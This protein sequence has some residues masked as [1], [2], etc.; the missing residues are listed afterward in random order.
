MPKS[1]VKLLPRPDP[2][3]HLS[4]QGYST[5]KKASTR[6]IALK[7]SSKKYGTLPVLKRLNLIRNLTPPDMPAHKVMASDVDYMS[8]L[9]KK[10]KSKKMSRQQSKKKSKKGS[11]KHSKK[12]SKK[13]SKKH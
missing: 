2:N 7:K 11:K 1:G 4:K 12:G 3:V 9:Y 6:H 8:K 10:E 5:S 13:G